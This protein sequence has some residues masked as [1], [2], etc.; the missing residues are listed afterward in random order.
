MFTEVFSPDSKVAH[1]SRAVDLIKQD[2]TC[3]SLLG[4]PKKILAHGEETHNKWKRAR[5]VA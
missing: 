5:P 3:R 2:P 1:F 4:E